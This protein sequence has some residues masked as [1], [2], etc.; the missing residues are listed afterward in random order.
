MNVLSAGTLD[1]QGNLLLT[2][3][4]TNTGTIGS[5]GLWKLNGTI[6]QTVTSSGTTT[7]ATLEVANAA[8]AALTAPLTVGTL[9]LSAGPLRL[10]AHDLTLTGTITNA[11]LTNQIVVTNG[12]GLLRQPVGTSPV[13]FPV[14]PADASLRSAALTRTTGTATYGVRA[15]TGALIGGTAGAPYAADAVALRWSVAAPDAVPDALGVQWASTDEL[16]SFDRTNAAL[17]RWTGSAYAP[18]TFG[19]ATAIGA[20]YAIALAGLTAGGPFVVLDRQAPLPVELTRFEVRRAAGQPR[21]QLSWAT[22]SELRNAGFE[23]QRQDEGQ[24]AFRRVGFVAGAGSSAQPHQYAFTDPNDFT[25]RSYYRLRQVD[26]DGTAVFSA[27]RVVAGLP[28]GTAFS[29]SAFPNPARTTATLEAAGP[30]PAGLHVVL[31]GA[32]GRRAWQADWPAGNTQL[33]V[34]VQGLAEGAYWLRYQAP[35]GP[36]G[37][38]PLAVQH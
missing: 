9:D 18:A 37:T 22:A 14:G 17:A 8:G 12:T 2:G 6:P 38:V 26:D 16:P 3:D 25:G 7:V 30:V 32:D 28:G 4:L 15:T 24:S 11:N 35:D 13:I 27:V 21:V 20:F 10:A 31:Y 33:P 36:A 19:A 34:P 29:L 1:N 5:T 23:V